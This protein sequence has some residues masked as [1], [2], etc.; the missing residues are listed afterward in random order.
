VIRKIIWLLPPMAS[1]LVPNQPSTLGWGGVTVFSQDVKV[2]GPDPFVAARANHP[3]LLA[4]R[5]PEKSYPTGH[6][7]HV[8]ELRA[9]IN[10]SEF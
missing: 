1:A 5:A 9:S 2:I 7:G 6:I 3:G 4:F 8:A 10:G